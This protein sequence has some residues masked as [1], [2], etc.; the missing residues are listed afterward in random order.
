MSLSL[1]RL[2]NLIRVLRRLVREEFEERSW[3]EDDSDRPIR[4]ERG[5]A[6]TSCYAS[7]LVQLAN[8]VIIRGEGF[9]DLSALKAAVLV[10]S[11]VIIVHMF[12][13]FYNKVRML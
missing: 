4:R 10:N 6:I 8:H 2:R 11:S 13:Y 12:F 5:K 9:F 3:A 7:Y 1:Y